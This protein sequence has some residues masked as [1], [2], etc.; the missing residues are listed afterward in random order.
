MV[1]EVNFRYPAPFVPHPQDE[2][3]L[4]VSGAEWFAALMRR[5]DGL[6]IDEPFVQEDWGV[7]LAAYRGRA[8]F[9]VHF[10]PGGSDGCWFAEFSLPTFSW[11]RLTAGGKADLARLV[12]DIDRLLSNDPQ[13]SEI[14]WGPWR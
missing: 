4:D 13:V 8:K 10:Q 9:W 14:N 2:G 12:T 5:I 1:N 3:I 11:R 7:A 6:R